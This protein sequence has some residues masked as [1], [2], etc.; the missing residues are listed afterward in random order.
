MFSKMLTGE[1]KSAAETIRN[2][3][4][5]SFAVNAAIKILYDSF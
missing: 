5:S 2:E 4:L 3:L 1:A